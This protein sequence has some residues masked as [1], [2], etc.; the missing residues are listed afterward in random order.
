M[1]GP[2][3]IPERHF[4]YCHYNKNNRIRIYIYIYIYS[5]SMNPGSYVNYTT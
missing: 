4:E 2:N 3:S 1:L 5:K